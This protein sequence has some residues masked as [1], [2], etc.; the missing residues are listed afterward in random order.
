MFL[1]IIA[2]RA[3]QSKTRKIRVIILCRKPYFCPKKEETSMK[4]L[5]ITPDSEVWDF[6]FADVVT[7]SSGDSGDN[8]D[9]RL[10]GVDFGS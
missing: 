3:N 6:S 5:Y 9:I 7:T 1:R 10:P 8:G 4:E 2:L